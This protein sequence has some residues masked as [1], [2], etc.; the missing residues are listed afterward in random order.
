MSLV[1]TS[2]TMGWFLTKNRIYESVLLIFVAFA[3]FR[4]DFFMDRIMPAFEEIEP[5][6]LSNTLDGSMEGDELRII[7][8]GPDFDTL[9][10]KDTTLVVKIGEGATGAERLEALGF[11]T[12][13]ED[14]LVKLD[15]PL[16]GTAISDGLSSFDFYADEPVRISTAKTPSDQLPKEL[17]FIPALLLLG[18]VAMMQRGRASGTRESEG[19]EA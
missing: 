8:S 3:L 17:I 13:E 14:G 15:E 19:A 5:A 12:L 4:P 2:G 18:L 16:F 10:M 1:F 7:V 9:E 6:A 11:V